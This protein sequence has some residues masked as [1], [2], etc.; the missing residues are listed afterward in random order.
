MITY[1]GS[2]TIKLDFKRSAPKVFTFNNQ[3]ASLDYGGL[4]VKISIHNNIRHVIV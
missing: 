3:I 4:T 2:D 1:N